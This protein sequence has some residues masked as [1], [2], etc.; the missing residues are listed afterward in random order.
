M[1]W[2]IE[3]SS[4]LIMILFI[5]F[6]AILILKMLKQIANNRDSYAVQLER[7]NKKLRRQIHE[8]ILDITTEITYSPHLHHT[9]KRG[10]LKRLQNILHGV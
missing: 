7:E 10:I 1:I 4:W 9:G 6:C 3:N 2:I 5:A 8:V